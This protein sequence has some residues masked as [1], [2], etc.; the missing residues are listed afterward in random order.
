MCPT[1]TLR[2][3]VLLI[4]W[5]PQW[6]VGQKLFPPLVQARRW[7]IPLYSPSPPSPT[8]SQS[9]RY[10]PKSLCNPF[11]LSLISA[12]ASDQASPLLIWAVGTTLPLSTWSWAYLAPLCSPWPWEGSL[13]IMFLSYLDSSVA[14]IMVKTWPS[15]ILLSYFLHPSHTHMQFS[16]CFLHFHPSASSYVLFPLPRISSFSN[17][18]FPPWNSS[19]L[20][21]AV[22]HHDKHHVLQEVWTASPGRIKAGSQCACL[23]AHFWNGPWGYKSLR[24]GKVYHLKNPNSYTIFCWF[25]CLDHNLIYSMKA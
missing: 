18:F 25:H 12:T 7:K 24:S 14:E 19:Y 22:A 16:S 21:L 5:P 13:Y 1:R 15:S 6:T 10:S 9:C 8:F 17:S 11:S 3:S 4:L 20:P 2:G 23:I